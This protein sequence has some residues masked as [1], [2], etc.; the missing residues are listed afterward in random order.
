MEVDFVALA[1]D[2]LT[3]VAPSFTDVLWSV[4]E[5]FAQFILY[6]HKEC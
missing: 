3:A 4:L 6:A 2:T 1:F 5:T